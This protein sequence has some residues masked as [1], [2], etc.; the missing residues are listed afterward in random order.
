MT[1]TLNSSGLIASMGRGRYLIDRGEHEIRA[2]FNLVDAE[3]L[4]PGFVDGL[5]REAGAIC[6]GIRKRGT[7]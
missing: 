3:S 7:A 6:A 1:T 2:G 5:I 4:Q